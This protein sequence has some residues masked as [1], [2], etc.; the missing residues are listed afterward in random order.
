VEILGKKSGLTFS[1]KALREQIEQGGWTVTKVKLDS[2]S[3]RYVVEAKNDSLGIKLERKGKTE[4]LALSNMLIATHH[5]ASSVHIGRWNQVFTGEM[6]EIAQAYSKAPLYEPK[7]SAAFMELA[8]DCERRVDVL[9]KHL[10]IQVVPDPEPYKTSEQ[11]IKDV[12]EHQRLKISR[13]GSEHPVWNEQQV[14]AYR[15]CH[16]VFGYVASGAGWDW[17]GENE[18]FAFHAHLIP[19][20]AQKALF[21]ESIASAAY[22]TYYRAYGQQKVALFPQFMDKAQEMN[23]PYKGHPG[24]HPSQTLPAGSEAEVK[25]IV[26]SFIPGIDEML[27]EA[28]TSLPS[29]DGPSAE[30]N[31]YAPLSGGGD[32]YGGG[33]CYYLATAMHHAFGLPIGASYGSDGYLNHAWVHDG[34]RAYDAYGVHSG[35][36]SPGYSYS[37]TVDLNH[38]PAEMAERVGYD[39]DPSEPYGNPNISHALDFA[40]R[41]FSPMQQH[42]SATGTG[43]VD[44]SLA[45]PNVG[46]QSAHASDPITGSNGLTLQEQY[47]DPIQ[48]GLTS[49]NANLI[50]TSNAPSTGGK[51]WAYLNQ[52]NP[53]ELAT[54]KKAIVNAFRTVL[55]SPRKDLRC[56]A[57]HYQDIS[58][59]P[60]DETD[61]KVYWDTLEQKRQEWNV[62]R[63]YERYGHLPYMKHMQNMVN[64]QYQRAPSQGFPAAQRSA[65]RLVQ[66]WLTEEQDRQMALDADK[67][68]SKQRPSFQ[69]E[70]KANYEL[71][72]RIKTYLAEHKPNLDNKATYKNRQRTNDMDMSQFAPTVSAVE[73]PP[74]EPPSPNTPK[75]VADEGVHEPGPQADM[76]KYGAFMGDHL[77]AIAKVSQYVDQILQAGIQDVHQHDGTGHHFRAIVL[78]LNIPGVGPKVCSFAWLLLQPMTS[79]LA[80]IDTHMMDL[81][82]HQEKEMNNRDYFG[83]ERELQAGRDAAGYQ[84][85]PMGQFQW[86]MWDYKRTGPGSHQD[87]SAM[88]VLDPKPHT[89]IDWAAKEQP[90]GAAGAVEWKNMWQTQPPEWWAQTLPARQQAWSDYQ[91]GTASG[92]GKAKVPYAG[93]PDGYQTTPDGLRPLSRTAGFNP[94]PWLIHPRSGEKIQGQPGQT[95]MS[96]AMGTLQT[97]DPRD[98][99]KQ[100][101]DE[102]V[103][104][105]TY[106]DYVGVDPFG[107]GTF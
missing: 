52:N 25:G 3:G 70:T 16:D 77:K 49:E 63:G 51:E 48:S 104:K 50:N 79:E 97:E 42:T 33:G 26:A 99:W 32:Y 41:N 47:G 87:H 21:V 7:A 68:A 71:E 73:P 5:R 62:S 28:N 75:G 12:K 76:S 54:M 53:G 80:T 106:N 82:G 83:M 20:E 11:L 57:I 60:G 56:N 66:K 44:P 61:P 107:L 95:I 45:D 59:I 46:W 100:F 1:H 35:A 85:M 101:P 84:H 78:Q 4:Q 30:E 94:V 105:T 89:S 23:N 18:A 98:V 38:D 96:H 92:V 40:E 72:K 88:S 34:K 39:Y 90:V 13:A 65:G 24:V 55:L 19:E 103:G 43:T 36:E 93:I 8:K 2:S 58:H 67:P 10:Q 22:A 14:V 31:D 74:I 9:S 81:L 102:S 64:T 86:G 27:R 15:I 69:I 17:A 29:L 37:N 6:E 91:S